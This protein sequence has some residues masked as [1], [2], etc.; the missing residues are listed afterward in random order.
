MPHDAD[1]ILAKAGKR[2]QNTEK[3]MK[4][5]N[6]HLTALICVALLG[7]AALSQ[8][9]I[10]WQLDFNGYANGDLNTQAVGQPGFPG[11]WFDGS[12]FV[13]DGVVTSGNSKA[14]L[15]KTFSAAVGP[16]GTLW[17]SFDWGHNNT[18]DHAST[19]GGLTFFESNYPTVTEKGLLGNNWDTATWTGTSISNIGMKTGVARITLS[20]TGFDTV[21]L[22]VGATG[23]PVDVSGA[24]AATLSMEL[25][26][27]NAF[28]I[29][30]GSNQQ[31]D[32]LV[33]GTTMGDVSAIPEPAS[34]GMLGVAAAAMLLRR[35]FRG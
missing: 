25:S 27:V 24:A 12:A 17:L 15:D 32:N 35:R 23:S 31:F 13:T 28:R 16:T 21:D 34:L 6:T 20:D 10:I 5:K 18:G 2:T 22:W 8:A 26:S 11:N 30:G 33:V 4:T 1:A 29:N 3:S 9:E 14:E 7:S 19:Y